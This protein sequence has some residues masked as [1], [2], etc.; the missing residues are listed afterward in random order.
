MIMLVLACLVPLTSCHSLVPPIRDQYNECNHP[1]KPDKPYT[2]VAVG[3]Y[4]INQGHA[5]DKCMAL[6]G[7]KE[8]Q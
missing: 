4:I 3:V 5:I 6:L 8:I 2:D 1:K 7:H